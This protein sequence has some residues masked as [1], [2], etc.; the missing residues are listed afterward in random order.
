MEYVIV[1]VTTSDD[2]EAERIGRSLVDKR[3]AACCSIIPAVKSIFRWK[4]D[5]SEENESQLLIK[6]RSVLLQ[7]LIRHVNEIHSYDT[8]EIIALPVL[9][10]SETYLQ[11]IKDETG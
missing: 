5:L 8:P 2:A 1:F 11:W 3:L 10:G 9:A 4:G 6:T 7:E